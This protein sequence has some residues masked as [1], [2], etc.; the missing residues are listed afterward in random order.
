MIDCAHSKI[1]VTPQERHPE[2]SAES[3]TQLTEKPY[4]AHLGIK[5]FSKNAHIAIYA[6]LF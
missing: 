3:Y 5:C 1:Q 2:R 6:A 4:L